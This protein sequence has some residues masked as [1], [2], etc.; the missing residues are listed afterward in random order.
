MAR[1]YVLCM[2]LLLV[3]GGKND[4]TINLKLGFCLWRIRK[5]NDVVLSLQI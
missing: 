2:I 4:V 5:D 1:L 3:S